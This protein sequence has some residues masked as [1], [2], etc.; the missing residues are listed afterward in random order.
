[1]NELQIFENSEFGSVRTVEVNGE[2]MFVGKDVAEILGYTN[3]R[4]AIGDHVDDED[5]GVTKCDTP[6]GLQ[7]LTVINESGLYSLILSSKL[8]SAKNFKRWI[9]SD[10]IP[11]IRKH[12]LYAVDELID[13][14][15]LAIKAFTAL[16][17][18]REKRLIAEQKIIE[19]KP[20]V[21]FATHVS[22]TKDTI[23]M[24]EMAKIANDEHI[25]IGRNRLIKWLKEK[26]VLRSNRTPYQSYIDR[27][28]FQV[29]EVKKD[30]TYGTRVFPKTVI[31]GKGQIWIVEKLREEYGSDSSTRLKEVGQ[32]M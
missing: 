15:E 25:S 19:Q 27:G 3:P 12:G 24:D 30:T 13:N 16:K 21:D 29:V 7:D 22:Q 17:E 5:K 10:V 8:P 4:K 2:P 14:P 6:G 28:Y 31:T 20:L 1:M 11:S 32:C 9:T 26:K 23:D 18:E